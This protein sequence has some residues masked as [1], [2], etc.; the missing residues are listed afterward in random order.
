M[1]KFEEFA[2]VND[3]RP[4]CRCPGCGRPALFAS[5]FKKFG[6]QRVHV[7]VFCRAVYHNGKRQEGE[8]E[9]TPSGVAAANEAHLPTEEA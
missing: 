7:C 8:V 1:S 9:V 5:A 3:P 6:E 4:E 2:R